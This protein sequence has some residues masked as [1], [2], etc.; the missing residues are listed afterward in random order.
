M[1]NYHVRLVGINWSSTR[2]LGQGR[3][4]KASCY[5]SETIDNIRTMPRPVYFRHYVSTQMLL[6]DT[7]VDKK[8][9]AELRM[10]YIV[11]LHSGS[12]I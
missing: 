5:I 8:E 6:T 10:L 9:V 11:V 1:R 3:V 12:Q 2:I 4:L 7:N